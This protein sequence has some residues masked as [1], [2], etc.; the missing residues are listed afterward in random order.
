MHVAT[1][2]TDSP[3][4]GRALA[5]ALAVGAAAVLAFVVAL[6]RFLPLDPF[7]QPV[8]DDLAARSGVVARYRHSSLVWRGIS[9]E[10]LEIAGANT[11]DAPLVIDRLV[12]QPTLLGLL[13]GRGG[14]P[15]Q[16]AA[17]LLAGSATAQLYGQP[18]AWSANVDWR[19]LDLSRLPMGTRPRITLSG[20]TDGNVKASGPGSTGGAGTGSWKISGGDISATGLRS[21]QLVLPPI[22]LGHLESNGTWEGPRLTIESLRTEG[23][24]GTASITGRIILRAPVEQ[25]A[26]SLRLTHSPPTTGSTDLSAMMRLLLPGG[27]AARGPRTYHVGGTLGLPAVRPADGERQPPATK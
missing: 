10:D 7:L 24:L 3:R 6:A 4:R 12:A 27:A 5:Y 18:P 26:L 11:P 20:V 1:V 15:W 2:T 22:A 23:P 8:V 21:G 16:L 17:D 19:K 14:L 13:R 9:L 25:S